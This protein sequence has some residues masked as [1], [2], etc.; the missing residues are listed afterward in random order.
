M[1]MQNW[2]DDSAGNTSGQVKNEP[3]YTTGELAKKFEISLRTLRF[4][5]SLE[6]LTP[7]RRDGRRIYGHQDAERLAAIVKAKKLGFTLSEARQIIADGT[8]PQALE[9]SRERCE[10]Q[11]AA[12]ERRFAEIIVA[13]AELRSMYQLL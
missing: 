10:A 5:E 11:I 2:N 12:L 4:Y 8:S 1:E 6:L 7:A 3:V 9:L 13:L